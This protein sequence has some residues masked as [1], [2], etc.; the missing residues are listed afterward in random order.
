MIG[1]SEMKSEL[2]EERLQQIEE[3]KESWTSIVQE[4]DKLGPYDPIPSF[5]K[6]HAEKMIQKLY[7]EVNYGVD[8]V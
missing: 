8:D 4:W 5:T 3:A 1:L 2:T 7:D 6:Q